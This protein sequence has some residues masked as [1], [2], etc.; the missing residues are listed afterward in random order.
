M[1]NKALAILSSAVFSLALSAAA[2]AT[3][4]TYDSTPDGNGVPMSQVSGATTIDFESGRCGGYADCSGNYSILT[5]DMPNHHAAPDI[6][7]GKDMTH[8]LTVPGAFTNRSGNYSATFQLGTQANYFGLM[9]GSIDRQNK[10]EFLLDGHVVD[11][12]TGS[13]VAQLVDGPFGSRSDPND[14]TYVNFFGLST[15]D[16]IRL[17]TPQY[18]FES[19]NHAF[20]MLGVPEPSGLALFALASLGLLAAAVRRRH[21]GSI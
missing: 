6:G 21:S 14:N 2:S 15:F 18:A 17:D 11:S 9:W 16:A 10:I 3:T 7:Q 19:D 8:Y 5:R 20:A 4:I 1:Y 12:F 13:E